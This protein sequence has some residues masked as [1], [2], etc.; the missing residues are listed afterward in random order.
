M[1][2]DEIGVYTQILQWR[3]IE[4]R[5]ESKRL[6]YGRFAISPF[7][8]G[9]AN[10]VGIAMRRSL[11]NEIDGASIISAEIKRVKHEY[12]T[13]SG[14]QES[15]HDILINL[16]EIVIKSDSYEPQKA[17]ISISGP[18]KVTAR[19]IEVP[20]SVR[21]I[22]DTQYITTLTEA[23]S[24]DIELNIEKDCGYRIEGS[25]GY[26]DNLFAIDA[27]FMPIRNV[28]YSVHSFEIRGKMKEILFLEIW[29]DG[30]LTPKEALYEASRNSIDLFIPLINSERKEINSEMEEPEES[31]TSSAPFQF[32]PS[33]MEEMTKDTAFKH[34]FID[35]SELP[36]RAYNCLK[37]VDVHTIADLLSYSENDLVKIKNFGKKSV[38]QV[39]EASKNRFSINLSEK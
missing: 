29:T 10:T 37:R 9:Q 20:P 19:D 4:S 25:Q 6:L 30:S 21:I 26:K 23:V 22:D 31:N 13:I 36:A 2:Q 11:L 39:L 33:D 34:I 7:R 1:I 18:K 16:K 27:V 5:M 24:L 38:E 12:S 32:L 3:C 17:Y 8:K 28:N 15:I 14:I 35:Q